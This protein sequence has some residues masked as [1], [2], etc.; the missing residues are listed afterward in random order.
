M[1]LS[2][3]IFLLL[4]HFKENLN[5]KR[6]VY[7]QKNADLVGVRETLNRIPWEFVTSSSD[8]SK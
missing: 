6:T 1:L 3:T 5:V 2:Q 4:L 8:L 7:S